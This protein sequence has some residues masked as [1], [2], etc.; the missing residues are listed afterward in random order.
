[1]RLLRAWAVRLM[2]VFRRR[3]A[4]HEFSQQIQADIELQIED[5]IRAGMSP[6]EARRAALLRSGGI[7]A[8]T[9][10][11]RDRHGL[12]FFENLYGDVIYAIR[13]LGRNKG[14]TTVAVVSLALGIGANTALFSAANGLF[15]RQLPVPDAH[16]LVTLRWEGENKAMT[17]FVD[18]G[19]VSGGP[20]PI[21]WFDGKITLDTFNAG[22]TGAYETFRRL[23][24]ANQTLE[25]LFA[26][27]NGPTVN[28]IVDGQGDI[29]SSQFV[30][31]EFYSALR[32]APAAGRHLLPTDDRKGAAPVAVVS[33]GYWQR[34]FGGDPSVVGKQVRINAVAFTIVGVSR[35][36]FPSVMS[37][38][39]ELPDISIPL[40]AERLFQPGESRL[41]QPTTW[42]L[43]MM[44]RLKPGVTAPEVEAN[45]GP[46]YEQACRDAASAMLSS[47]S[48]EDSQDARKYGFGE[49][50][51]SV[52]VVS[53]ARGA[54]DPLPMLQVPLAILGI[55]VGILLLVV[56][57]NLVNLSLA[58]TTSRQRE[59]AV[60]RAIG[61]T[62]GRLI[63]QILTEHF[64]IAALGGGASLL[65]AYLFQEL[66]R[67]YFPVAFGW[68]TAAFAFAA[69]AVTAIVIGILP[70]LRASRPP[71]GAPKR[72][73]R[74]ASALLVTQVIM[75]LALLVGA[76]LFLGT[77]LNLQNVDPGFNSDGLVLFTI[78]P[79]FN[80]YDDAK[81]E[82]LYNELT[83]NLGALPGVT[84]VSFSSS[85]LLG[86]AWS[87]SEVYTEVNGS[88]TPKQ[89]A[90]T[91]VVHEDFFHTMEI[92]LRR[93]RTFNAGDNAAAPKVAIVNE[94]F[95]RTLFGDADPVG[96]RFGGDEDDTDKFE[97][98]GVVAD[99]RHRSLRAAPPQM[100]FLPHLQA[101]QGARTF[102][103][104]TGPSAEAMMSAI[105]QVVQ[106]ADPALP[107]I[108]LST[109]TSALQ[110]Q[111]T[112]ERI[113][114]LA[115]VTLGG[116]TL[117]VSMIGL[118]GMMSY[119]VARRTKEIAIRMALG[120][121]SGGVLRSVLGEALTLV[122]IGILIG[123]GVALATTRFLRT[124]LYGLSPTDPAVIGGAVLLMIAVAAA[125]AYLPAR[126]A[127]KVDPIVALR[128]E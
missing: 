78:E 113:I 36:G 3:K 64:V 101:D 91:L 73:P 39:P 117:A 80:Q 15:L 98:V 56:C 27:A 108:A 75:S 53:G 47:L 103:V 51:P 60:R 124:L 52:N 50:I 38:G 11:W 104:R 76:G 81:T 66:L 106:A 72:R 107:V 90:F 6:A 105:R 67:H 89:S 24:A 96:R 128:E 7:D 16:D 4:E 32:A 71:E 45:L 9:E 10:A 19:F 58:L 121:Q 29:A 1:M 61:A 28:L 77:L 82:A 83:S 40:A 65:V 114:A 13:V 37:G 43:V 44:G 70:A 68:S 18:Y 115:S 84:S 21:N 63:R 122:V 20:F 2:S 109:Y 87:T 112:Q 92:P 86:N 48:D 34:R 99:T 100:F 59:I 123:L 111:W 46:I 54:Y 95:A 49:R 119:A 88:P 116:L 69:A 126:R 127:A 62:R 25:Y 118:F 23:E 110:V 97:I 93:G 94:A 57:A 8:A 12:P 42:W 26:V 30:S 85:S 79:A 74:L 125:A 102:E 5:G 55:L 31:G 22:V 33:Y 41:D 14:W 17:N 120:A 35:A